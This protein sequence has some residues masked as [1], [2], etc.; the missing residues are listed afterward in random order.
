M[1]ALRHLSVAAGFCM[2]WLGLAGC[3]TQEV[4]PAAPRAGSGY[5]DFY[6]DSDMDL[7]WD[8]KCAD[9]KT[10]EMQTIYSQMK[11]A[12][13]T[14]L[15]V[16]APPGERRF[17]VWI[18]NLFTVGPETAQ[19]LVAEGKVTPVHVTLTPSSNTSVNRKDY[20]F[21]GSAKGYA[22][23]TKIVRDTGEVF[24]IGLAPGAPATYQRKEQMPYWS[25]KVE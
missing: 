23:G 13:G 9:E 18:Q 14:I 2:I 16:A 5:V 6:T 4:N 10:G 20:A 17:Q 21:R 7:S 12:A 19:V 25:L 22:R 1:K 8:V 15:R 11:P 24:H 3:S